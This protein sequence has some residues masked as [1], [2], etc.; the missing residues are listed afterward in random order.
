[1]PFSKETPDKDCVQS[2]INRVKKESVE[3]DKQIVNIQRDE[4]MAEVISTYHNRVKNDK[5]EKL[6]E[7]NILKKQKENYEKKIKELES[8]QLMN[9]VLTGSTSAVEEIFKEKL[10]P[11]TLATMAVLLKRYNLKIRNSKRIS[12]VFIINSYH[13]LCDVTSP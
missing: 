10:A 6:A 3:H 9:T 12:L 4:R 11:E 2:Q 8:L 5:K 1:M 13:L 7:L